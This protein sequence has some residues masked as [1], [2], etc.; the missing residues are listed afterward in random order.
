MTIDSLRVFKSNRPAPSV[1]LT[2]PHGVPNDDCARVAD[3]LLGP[4]GN[5]ESD[6]LEI[7]NA[8]GAPICE[9]GGDARLGVS[10]AWP[11]LLGPPPVP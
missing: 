8:A 1:L 5:L 11:D 6:Y 4:F 3:K 7:K 2:A 10:E 9:S